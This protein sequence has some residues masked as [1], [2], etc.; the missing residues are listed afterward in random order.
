MKCSK[1]QKGFGSK[2]VIEEFLEGEEASFIAIVSGKALGPQPA[3]P[4]HR[5]RHSHQVQHG[6]QGHGHDAGPEAERQPP[7]LTKQPPLL[8]KPQAQIGQRVI[9]I[10]QRKQPAAIGDPGQRGQHVDHRNDGNEEDRHG[11]KS[12]ISQLGKLRGRSA[13]DLP[14]QGKIGEINLGSQRALD[15][16]GQRSGRL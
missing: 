1:C 6:H 4:D 13:N 7:M 9:A 15:P 8:G 3:G 11:K 10:F 12:E 14:G 5:R 2:G 16:L